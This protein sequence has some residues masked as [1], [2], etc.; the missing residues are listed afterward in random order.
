MPVDKVMSSAGLPAQIPPVLQPTSVVVKT[1]VTG[2]SDLQVFSGAKGSAGAIINQTVTPVSLNPQA[3]VQPKP[4]VISSVGGM[5]GVQIQVLGTGQA[6]MAV[7]QPPTAVQTHTTMKMPFTAEPSKE[8]RLLEQLRKQQGSV[9]HPNYSAPFNTFEDTLQRLLPYHLYQGNIHSS[10]DYDKVDEEFETVSSLLLKRTQAMVDKYRHLLFSE[11]KQRLGPSAE[12]VMIDRMFIQEEKVALSQDRILAKEKPDEFLANVRK[13]ESA[14]FSPE[15]S[16]TAST[17]AK[18][19]SQDAAASPTP[20]VPVSSA[21]TPNVTPKPLTPPAPSAPPP[22]VSAPV[23]PVSA[24]VPTTAPAPSP[25]PAASP[26]PSTKLVIKQGGA[27]ASVSWSSSCPTPPVN[28][29]KSV[30]EP[31]VTPSSSYSRVSVSSSS[32]FSSSPFNSKT[33]DDDDALLQRTSKP[34]IKTYEARR[35]IGLKLKIKQDQTGF[36]KV[37]H[38]TALDPVHTPQPSSQ[39]TQPSSNQLNSVVQDSKSHPSSTPTVIRTQTPVCTS[40]SSVCSPSVNTQ[41]NTEFKSNTTHK[42]SPSSLSNPAVQMNGTVEHHSGGAVKK[43]PTASST[44]SQ[45]TC[46]LPLRK[47]YRENVSPRVRPG[48]PGGGDEGYART[49]DSPSSHKS[50]S[51]PLERTVIASVKVEKRDNKEHVHSSNDVGRLESAMHGLERVD[52]VFSRGLKTSKHNVSLSDMDC[53][54]ERKGE[55]SDFETSESKYKKMKNRQRAGGTFRM[56]QHAPG[57][58]SPESFTRDPLLP[59][60]RCK[61]DSPDMDNASFSSGSPPDDSLNEHLQCAIDSILNLQQEP[62]GH[63][64][65]IKGRPHHDHH[66][67]GISTSLS[68]RPSVL[69]SASASS[70]APHPQV[71]G[72]GHNGSLVPQTQSR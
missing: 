53:S 34:P 17:E 50:S 14:V 26:F 7:P 60:K 59:A 6:Q 58:P 43:N 41:S 33:S 35:R 37:V 32:H 20:V 61:S 63:G 68:H 12:M 42:A 56:D 36:S 18:S 40:S 72:R 38:N 21:P 47:T 44:S 69:P 28:S 1:P 15:K 24:P 4:G 64:T 67:P 29:T 55:H 22:P 65:H 27:G 48:I 49:T 13:W 3:Q 16:S 39:S 71:R 8:A 51:P 66:L 5:G 9:L 2:V 70:L 19:G 25:A 23:A 57:P 30:T 52:E 10:D 46:R 62:T 31:T 11:S 54:K 45:T